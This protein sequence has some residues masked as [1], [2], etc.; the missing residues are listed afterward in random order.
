MVDDDEAVRA[1]QRPV[2]VL[3]QTGVIERLAAIA[4]DSLAMRWS[5]GEQQG[6]VRRRMIA[7][8]RKQPALI[9]MRQVEETVPGHEAV[10]CL[11][12]RERS[13]VGDRPRMIGETRAAKGNQRGRGTDPGQVKAPLDEI[14]PDRLR[15][16]AAEIEDRSAGRQERGKPV[17]PGLFEQAA[18]AIGVP[19][20][21]MSL[22]EI[23]DPLG[24]RV[25]G[26]GIRHRAALPQVRHTGR[27]SFSRE[28][29]IRLRACDAATTSIHRCSA[30]LRSRLSPAGRG[31]ISKR[32]EKSG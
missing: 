21:G 27:A 9:R 25:H 12:E 15:R 23:D 31:R 16:S 22:V 6:R 24:Q 20:A 30:D 1:Q 26:F 3:G 18:A 17:E 4:A 7:D 2:L 10:E 29:P 19:F 32:S 8:D 28:H 13:H 14:S 11:S 5:A